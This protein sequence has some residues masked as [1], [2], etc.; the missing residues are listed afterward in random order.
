M[1]Q[2]LLKR[3]A[4]SFLVLILVVIVISSIIY[5][6]PVDPARLTFGQ[7]TDV[8]SIEAKKR[9]LG[10][11]K[12]LFGQLGDYL[13]DISPIGLYQQEEKIAYQITSTITSRDTVEVGNASDQAP[14]IR[15]YGQ[16][17]I[18]LY[19]ALKDSL[20]QSSEAALHQLILMTETK[21]KIDKIDTKTYKDRYN[22]AKLFS[23]GSRDFIV[24]TP[25]L[26]KS[27]QDG[28]PVTEILLQAIP[29]TAILALSA[30]FIGTIIG[31]FLGV[32]AALN[33]NTWIDNFSVI[34]S[35]FG[36]SLPSYVTGLILAYIFGYL[37]SDYTGLS[38]QGK[39]FEIN[40]IGEEILVWRN[41]LLPALALGIRPV[42]LVTQLTRSAMLDVLSQDYIR[43]AHAKGLA[44]RKVNFKHALR[45]ALNPVTTAISG[46]FASLLAG[47][48]FIE[49]IFNFDGLGL[50]TIN[51]LQN[52]DL[53]VLLGS[54]LFAATV[55]VF[56][57]IFVD[58]IYA[59]LDPRVRI[60]R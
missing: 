8:E 7:R 17:D 30:I 23:I 18:A 24:K 2:Y 16:E 44:P 32:F 21:E 19:K 28:R 60:N 50:A 13:A 51:A 15:Q 20:S 27:F 48:F 49:Y 33:R 39:L 52:Y 54:V 41:L 53:P 25:Y 55:F 31:L 35:V 46:W 36:Y 40:D 6:S 5:L 3:I 29:Q 10:L 34:L 9:E 58:F 12:S 43:T 14:I 11:D 42:A 47:A 1:I 22:Y 59:L 38:T 57:N 26:R 37:L 56:I 45:N 4:Y